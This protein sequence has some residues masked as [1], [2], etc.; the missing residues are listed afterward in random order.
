MTYESTQSSYNR[1]RHCQQIQNR[2]LHPLQQF[3][4]D[5]RQ[6][7]DAA[8]RTRR[9]QHTVKGLLALSPAARFKQGRQV[10][11]DGRAGADHARLG[12]AFLGR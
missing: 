10:G 11:D 8:V 5:R 2:P 6:F 3:K 4:H 12:H 9:G 1:P 7:N